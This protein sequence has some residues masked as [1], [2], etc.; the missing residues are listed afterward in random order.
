MFFRLCN[1]FRRRSWYLR[2]V[3]LVYLLH[4]WAQEES[5][6]RP[7]GTFT[8]DQINGIFAS[9]DADIAQAHSG[10][11]MMSGIERQKFQHRHVVDSRTRRATGEGV[12]LVVREDDD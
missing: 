11:P 4:R 7:K 9:I 5:M 10:E 8:R 12:R 2:Y 3:T 1:R 6:S